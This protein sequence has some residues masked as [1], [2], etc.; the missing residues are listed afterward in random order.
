[1]ASSITFRTS[2]K[3]GPTWRLKRPEQ[4]AYGYSA[5]LQAEIFERRKALKHL[6][7]RI[8]TMQ[9]PVSCESAA[10]IHKSL[11]QMEK[12]LEVCEETAKQI[13]ET[14]CLLAEYRRKDSTVAFRA[15]YP[16]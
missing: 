1:M 3:N 13:K 4:A 16:A 14:L 11:D 6:R 10:R 7:L 9:P 8:R 15:S 12:A 2:K 5:K